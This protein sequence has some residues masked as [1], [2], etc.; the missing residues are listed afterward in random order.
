MFT[1]MLKF[2][3]VMVRPLRPDRVSTYFSPVR[4][5]ETPTIFVEFGSICMTKNGIF[6]H[7]RIAAISKRCDDKIL[8]LTL[9]LKSFNLFN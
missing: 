3:I 4:K 7:I 8:K 2:L 1:I 6:S 9:I 5:N